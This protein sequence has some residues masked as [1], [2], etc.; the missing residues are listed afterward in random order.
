MFRKITKKYKNF[1]KNYFM[2]TDIEGDSYDYELLDSAV[3]RIK[4]PIGISFEIGVRRGMGSKTIIDAY[5]KYHPN[6]NNLYVP[7]YSNTK[8]YSRR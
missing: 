6:M 8:F 2:I 1:L 7:V 5:R 4:N 3:K